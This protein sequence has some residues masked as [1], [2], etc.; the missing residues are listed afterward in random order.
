MPKLKFNDK[1]YYNADQIA[2]SIE[3]DDIFNCYFDQSPEIGLTM[4][5]RPGLSEFAN[6]ATG[7]RGQGIYEWEAKGIVLAVSNGRTY[8]LEENGT[9]ADITTAVLNS[10]IPVK[11]A[12]GSKLDGTPWLYMANGKLVYSDDGADTMYPTD[13]NTP[14]TADHVVYLNLRFLAN[15][16]GTNQF[17]FTDTDP[18]T[19]ALEPDYWSSSDNPLTCEARGDDLAAMT[20][21]LQEIYNWGTESQEV[22]QD[23]G[24][25][26]A[27]IP[28]AASRI[29]IEAPHSIIQA[30]NTLFALCV[31]DGIR[32]VVKMAGRTP[33]I[34]SNPIEN[35]LSDYGTV[36]DAIGSLISVGGVHIYLLQ[37]P[38]AG[39]T[40]AYDIKSDVWSPWGTWDE[41]TGTMGQFIGQ[42]SCYVKSWNKHLIMSKTD[43]KIYEFDRTVYEDDENLV[44]TYRRTAWEEH[45]TGARKRIPR[46]RI[47][48]K[49][50]ATVT[51]AAFLRWAD[52]G[53][54]EWSPYMELSL[55]PKGKRN[56]I[57]DL[58]QMGIYNSRRYE[59]SI[60]DDA[61]LA[62]IWADET[63]EKL[64]F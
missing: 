36:S 54:E 53:A 15:R 44:K 21:F 27:P 63:V 38:S 58:P 5:R 31:V 35:V 62:F 37:L 45:D 12:A 7:S 42:H 49:T 61:D 23:D 34:V 52:D 46:L 17:L 24:S 10:E 13:A 40:W 48:I 19:G 16:P 41:A 8:R 55:H 22:W 3:P 18:G 6:L 4:R 2:N 26:F 25:P 59:I 20:E 47:K 30:D 39:K 56:F 51:G 50:G 43:G 11:F 60:T 14:S 9:F 1:P 28:Q 33:Q 29:G 32:T 57:I 64:R